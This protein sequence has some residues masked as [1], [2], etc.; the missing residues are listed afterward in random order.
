MKWAIAGR[1]RDKLAAVARCTERADHRRRRAG[2][3]G[4]RRRSRARTKVICTTVGPYAKYGS[5]VVAACAAA[6]THYCDLTGE[7]HWMRAMI[8]AHHET[9]TEDRRAD[10][11]RVRASTRSRATSARG[12]RSKSSSTRFGHPA[13][14][15]TAYYGALSG[16]F[17]GGTV[18]SMFGLADAMEDREVR[19]DR[20]Q[21]VRPRSGS[22][23]AAPTRARRQA[24]AVGARRRNV[25][26]AVRD[27]ARRTRAS[28]GAATRSPAF[29][30]ATTS[31]IAR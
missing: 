15:V 23:R 26:R 21:S 28:C 12:R 1:N 19:R 31:S 3:E 9:A 25:H 16:G 29:R 22:A 30:G 8:D 18:G 4:V 6:G 20:R 2:S 13:Q 10:R 24:A 17:S 11:A 14:K 27:G 7:V 5:D